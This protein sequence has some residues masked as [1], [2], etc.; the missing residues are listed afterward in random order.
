MQ[1]KLKQ[2]NS[3]LIKSFIEI[4]EDPENYEPWVPYSHQGI[5]GFIDLVIERPSEISLFKFSRE[6]EKI[7]KIIK[8]FKLEI[9]VY[10]KSRNMASK[11]IKSYLVFEDSKKNRRK[12]LSQEKLLKKQPFDIMF[13]DK[14]RGRI[15]SIFE[16]R[17]SLP[18]LFQTRKI[19]LEPRALQE[20]FTNP[21]H[22]QISRALINLEDPP[23]K[24]TRKLVRKTERYIERN[25][26]FPNRTENLEREEKESRSG[27]Y[28]RTARENDIKKAKQP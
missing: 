2:G 24:I 18:R 26:E 27:S 6:A 21:N 28:G 19:R 3:D 1:K 10:P 9:I 17:D 13:L 8:N 15:E 4:Q 7:E 16:L 11:E 20:L 25:D 22:D 23:D 12:V 14:D 5:V